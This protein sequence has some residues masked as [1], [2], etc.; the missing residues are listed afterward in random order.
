MHRRESALRWIRARVVRA[1][2]RVSRANCWCKVQSIS[3]ATSEYF[4]LTNYDEEEFR[5][6]QD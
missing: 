1:K 4:E 6:I 2:T 3:N 5:G